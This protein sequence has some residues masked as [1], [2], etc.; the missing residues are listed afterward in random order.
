MKI[1]AK[2][3]FKKLGY[4]EER[5]LNERFVSYKKPY[6]TGFI[7]IQFDLKDKTYEAFYLG[8]NCRIYPQSLSIKEIL[9]I[10]KQFE[11]LGDEFTYECRTDV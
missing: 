11:E 8:Q 5:I 2:G 1:T 4:Q 7:Y 3:L 6:G 9:A 10:Q